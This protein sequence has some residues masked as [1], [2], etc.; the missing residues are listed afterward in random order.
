MYNFN[1]K[2]KTDGK[3]KP[4]STWKTLQK[5]TL[6]KV[7]GNERKLVDKWKVYCSSK[8]KNEAHRIKRHEKVLRQIQKGKDSDK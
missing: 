5:K 3:G 8:C 1:W 7:C 2:R 6:C 4:T